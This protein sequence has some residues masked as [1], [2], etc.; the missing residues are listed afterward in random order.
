MKRKMTIWLFAA[1]LTASL[2]ACASL[3]KSMISSP[4][5]FLRD[6]QLVGL[7]FRHQ[8]FLL[9]FDVANPN[10]FA[11]PV[12]NVGYGVK[13]DGQLFASGETASNFTVPAN[14]NTSFAISVDIN[15]LSTAPQLLTIVRNG[16]QRDIHYDL[17]G[18][19]GVDL[20]LAPTLKYS[21]SGVIRVSSSSD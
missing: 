20:P 4:Q 19:L 18:R 5:V 21:D 10:A 15:L 17:E 7:D 12:R 13:L 6:V 14:G 2:T 16:T 8:T 1:L 11:L 9:S 3:T